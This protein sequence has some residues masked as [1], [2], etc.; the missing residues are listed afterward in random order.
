MSDH[1]PGCCLAQALVSVSCLTSRSSLSLV[2]LFI[3]SRP[4]SL[5][6]FRGLSDPCRPNQMVS[7]LPSARESKSVPGPAHDLVL[8][9]LHP[10]VS[11]HTPGLCRCSEAPGRMLCLPTSINAI[12]SAWNAPPWMF[13]C[14]PHAVPSSLTQILSALQQGL[15]SPPYPKL[16]FSSLS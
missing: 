15:S 1:S 7:L 5:F 9:C 6:S 4:Y 14:L 10:A 13:T 12:P 8:P 2:P 16:H 3:P 11:P